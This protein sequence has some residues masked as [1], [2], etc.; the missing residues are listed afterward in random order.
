MPLTLYAFAPLQSSLSLAIQGRLFINID[1]LFA[2]AW[3]E[4]AVYFVIV[5]ARNTDMLPI[6]SLS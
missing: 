2:S 5:R 1:L 6:E 3:E 4:H